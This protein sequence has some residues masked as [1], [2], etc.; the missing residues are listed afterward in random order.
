[1]WQRL[2]ELRI[3]PKPQSVFRT[4]WHCQTFMAVLLWNS[5]QVAP[6]LTCSQKATL[7]NN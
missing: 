5:K 7:E 1:M 3:T 6:D 2:S 4:H